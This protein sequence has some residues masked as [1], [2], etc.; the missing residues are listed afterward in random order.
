M[1]AEAL[2]DDSN[3]SDAN[4]DDSLLSYLLDIR[5]KGDNN[6]NKT[7]ADVAHNQALE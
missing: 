3:N 7:K 4:A 1:A 2:P 5:I 6:N